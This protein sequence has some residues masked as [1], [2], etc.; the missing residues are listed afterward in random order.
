VPRRAHGTS[1]AL[2]KRIALVPEPSVRLNKAITIDGTAGAASIR[3]DARRRARRARAR[4]HNEHRE[5][6][7]ETQR[8]H[9]LKA[10]STCATGRSS[11]EP[12]GAFCQGRQKESSAVSVKRANKRSTKAAARS[13]TGNRYV[14]HSVKRMKTAPAHRRGRF[15][16]DLR[17]ADMLER[18]SCAAR[19]PTPASGHRYC[20]ARKHPA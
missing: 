1:R 19:T 7:L 13:P 5:K 9:G 4:L 16:A 20:S 15:L 2:A 14:G 8:E 10:I 3:F 18:R 17:F 11:P 6:L 12:M